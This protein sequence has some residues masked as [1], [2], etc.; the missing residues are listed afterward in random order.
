MNYAT[1]RP[2]Y[3]R[4]LGDFGFDAE[5]DERA[6]DRLA[7][8]V[9]PFD[10]RRLDRIDGATVAVAGAGPSLADETAV[11]AAADVVIAASAAAETLG[12]S[13]VDVMVT[14]LDKTPDTARA[15][16]RAGV[17]VAVHA[18]GDNLDA[19]EEWVPRFDGD[20]VLPTT[21]AEPRGPVVNYGGF[22]DGDR[23]AFLAD[24]FGADR[25]R[26]PGWDFDDPSV[27]PTKRRK[28]A[29]AERLLH[30]LERRR[31]DRFSVLDGRRE[32]IDPL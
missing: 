29:W 14:D 30:W 21:Q 5:A 9:D 24:A 18:H 3:R 13:G 28:L 32:G 12:E 17:P 8:Q 27:S 11:A 23:A 7:T 2:V 26:F 31:D 16:T 6:R 4:I 15:L 20:H 19:V 1:W 22:T 10:E 25:L